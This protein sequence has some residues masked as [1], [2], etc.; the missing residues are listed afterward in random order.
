VAAR[1]KNG[2][3][4]AAIDWA[5]QAR[6]LH[7]GMALADAR[8]AVP[9][10]LVR[11]ADEAVDRA[12]LEAVAEWCDRF[13]PLVALDPPRGLFLDICGCAHLF[14]GEAALR[15]ELLARLAA[16]GLEGRAAIAATAGAAWAAA[17]HGGPD[18]IQTGEESEMLAGLPVAALRLEADQIALLDKLGLKCI[19]QIA[20]LPRAPLTARF[21]PGLVRR[22]DQALGREDEPL[23]PRRPAPEFSAERRFADP[24]GDAETV[25]ATIGALAAALAA[26]L[27]R[28]GAG[29]RRLQLALFR[30]DGG[31]VRA[32]LGTARPVR[33]AG[34]VAALFAERLQALGESMEAGFGFD[35]VRLSVTESA[36][37]EA[38]QIDLSGAAAGAGLD[39]LF[40]LLGARLGL[41]RV[42]RL[43]P[44][45]S[46]IPERACRALP[47]VEAAGEDGS[48]RR[49]NS[50]PP[51]RERVDSH[52]PEPPPDRPLRL[53]ARPEPVEVIAE[54][55]EGP[56]LRFRWRRALHHVALAEGPERIAPEWWRENAEG[57]STRD[58]YRVE[59]SQGRRFWLYRA[60]LYGRETDRPAW[61]MHGLFT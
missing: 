41:A 14:G 24:I 50:P 42:T 59:D 35:M 61:F 17:H 54:V 30:A 10:L 21:G 47:L 48:C 37:C 20:G 57:E 55:P 26:S 9:D 40:D 25:S 8:A 34:L 6:G 44:V 22:L 1:V 19:D 3:R 11:E 31:V 2:L 27:E 39:R 29:A 16:S 52:L 4:L 49:Q 13:T 58:Y 28:R 38:H 7:A 36:P 51:R 56:P 33:D 60:G 32:D 23:S 12:L 43:A 46:H 18:L 45:D 53:F 5:A 15:A